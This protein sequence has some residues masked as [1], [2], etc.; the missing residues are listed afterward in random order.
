MKPNKFVKQKLRLIEEKPGIKSGSAGVDHFL[1]HMSELNIKQKCFTSI[2]FQPCLKDKKYNDQLKK[3]Q[4]LN[5]EAHK[6]E[7]LLRKNM[8]DE[9]KMEKYRTTVVRKSTQSESFK[10]KIT[11]D[12]EEQKRIKANQCCDDHSKQA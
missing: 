6:T 5:E 11:D 4:K 1:K 9:S 3:E 7:L 2:N 12:L 10:Q 8:V